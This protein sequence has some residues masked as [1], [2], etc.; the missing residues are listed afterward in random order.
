MRKLFFAAFASV[1]LVSFATPQSGDRPK[2]TKEGR[3]ALIRE[4]FGGFVVSEGKGSLVVVNAQ[5]DFDINRIT[6]SISLAGHGLRIPVAV[7]NGTFAVADAR[8][9]LDACGG[10]IGVFVIDDPTMPMSL[11]STE[12]R[13]GAVNIA[14]LKSGADGEK[15]A[16]RIA[17]EFTRV[18][19]LT[20]CG[21]TSSQEASVMSPILKPEDLDKYA[22]AWI[23]LDIRDI[24]FGNVA[25]YGIVRTTRMT[26]RKACEEGWAPPPTN[27]IQKAI[28]EKVHSIPDKPLK[29][30]FDPAAQKGKVTK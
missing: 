23:P 5:K 3:E 28:W 13:W 17:K 25:C 6:N 18:L 21:G 24:V 20:L 9:E 15:L 12:A 10:T 1:T 16:L 14:P 26:Y 8:R 22:G 4:K 27:D 29:I 30:K 7:K 11:T 2:L 19:M